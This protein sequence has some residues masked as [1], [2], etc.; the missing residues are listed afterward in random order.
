M[1]ALTN[2]TLE[3]IDYLANG[4][5]YRARIAAEAALADDTSKKNAY[6][7][8]RLKNKLAHATVGSEIKVP[9]KLAS[10]VE[11]EERNGRFHP[12]RYYLSPREDLLIDHVEKIKKACDVFSEKGIT[13]LN[14]LLLR[15]RSGTGKT[16]LARF[17]AH[18]FEL[19]FVYLNFS[20]VISSY[21]GT[22]SNNIFDIFEFAKTFPCVLMLD[23]IDC[24]GVSRT[25]QNDAAAREDNRTI[26]SLMQ[27]FDRLENNQIVIGAT[28]V[29]ELDPA[30]MRR[31]SK[32]HEVKIPY[33][34]DEVKQIV[35]LFLSSAQVEY[36]EEN[37]EEYAKDSEGKTQARIVNETIETL[38]QCIY[39]DRPFAFEI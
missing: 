3:L 31:F 26:V 11:V 28:N 37:V 36:Q 29:D 18:K 9:P 30:L 25:S 8:A 2:N 19:P 1:A 5:I 22:T 10:M 38:A 23:E 39:S 20:T 33:D 35:T 21:R 24:I 34:M 27:A 6:K 32:I 13:Y 16:T 7:I 14:T 12:E 17:I 15:G 4:D